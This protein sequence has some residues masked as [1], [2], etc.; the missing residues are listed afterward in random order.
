M[1]HLKIQRM[2][3][4]SNDGGSDGDGVAYDDANLDETYDDVASNDNY[5]LDVDIQAKEVESITMLHTVEKTPFLSLMGGMGVLKQD[6][7]MGSPQ[8]IYMTKSHA[9]MKLKSTL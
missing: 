9:C 2:M 4:G 5:A 3:D 1:T 7:E 6:Q 8:S